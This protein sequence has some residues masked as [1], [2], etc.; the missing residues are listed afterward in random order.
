M[1]K[2]ESPKREPL[3]RNTSYLQPVANKTVRDALRNRYNGLNRKEIF[4]TKV[5]AERFEA[6]QFRNMRRRNYE[7]VVRKR[8]LFKV[9]TNTLPRKVCENLQHVM[10]ESREIMISDI[11]YTLLHDARGAYV[12]HLDIGKQRM[13]LRRVK[14]CVNQRRCIHVQR[15]LCATRSS[16]FDELHSLENVDCA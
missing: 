14:L 6:M 7:K 1:Q 16:D 9:G 10:G 5:T 8:L 4:Y 15:Y 2:R 11:T 13:K 3:F 12:K